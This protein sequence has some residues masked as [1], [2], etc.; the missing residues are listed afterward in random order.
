MDLNCD[1]FTNENNN[2]N[3][4]FIVCVRA[5]YK[6]KNIS[7]TRDLIELNAFLYL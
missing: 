7:W 4:I 6:K 3:N 5:C 1:I 2:V